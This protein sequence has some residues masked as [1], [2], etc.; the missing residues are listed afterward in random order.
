MTGYPHP[1]CADMDCK[2]CPWCDLET[3]T[4]RCDPPK[5]VPTR[6]ARNDT[7][8]GTLTIHS[9][10]TAWPKINPEHD[11]CGEHPGRKLLYDRTGW[12][13]DGEDEKGTIWRLKDW[14]P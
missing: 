2:T 5:V 7:Y 3:K 12:V 9:A 14:A 10:L 1:D 6:Y 13:E 4:C 11:W 8:Y